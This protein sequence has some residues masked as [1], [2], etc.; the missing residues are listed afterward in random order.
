MKECHVKQVLPL[1]EHGFMDEQID[2]NHQSASLGWPAVS[3]TE[4]MCIVSQY[5]GNVF[6]GKC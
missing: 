2:G 5:N 1:F 6:E 3:Q 4:I